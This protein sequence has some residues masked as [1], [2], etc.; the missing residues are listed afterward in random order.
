MAVHEIGHALGIDHN[1]N[2]ES[3]MFPSYIPQPQRSALPDFDRRTIQAK[4]GASNGDENDPHQP[5]AGKLI[6]AFEMKQNV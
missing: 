4:Y 1:N 2:R 3:I 6:G 5:D